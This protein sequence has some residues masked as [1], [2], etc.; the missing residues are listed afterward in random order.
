MFD[1]RTK[2]FFF[3]CLKDAAGAGPALKN[4]APAPGSGKEKHRLRLW[5]RSRPKSGGSRRLWLRNTGQNL[6]Q[7]PYITYIGKSKFT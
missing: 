5:L 1:I 7:D 6:D 4:A 3:A 2:V